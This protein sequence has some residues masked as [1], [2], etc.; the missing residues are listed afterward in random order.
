MDE[1][2]QLLIKVSDKFIYLHFLIFRFYVFLFINLF[3]QCK[4]RLRFQTRR[5]LCMILDSQNLVQ[6]KKT[7]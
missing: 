4:F 7:I 3:G 2:K 5:L 1:L 6:K